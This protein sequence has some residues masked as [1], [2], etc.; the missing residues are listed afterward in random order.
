M[1][2]ITFLW[3][4]SAKAQKETLELPTRDKIEAKYKWNLADIY[5][6]DNQWEKDFKW[7]EN[8]ITEYKKYEGKLS[9][10]AKMLK[11]CLELDEKVG[12][13]LSQAY[14]YASMSKDL[15]LTN[16][17][18]QDMY[19]KISTLASKLSA[20]SA[21][22]KP[23]ILSIPEEKLWEYVN[24]DSY[25]KIYKHYFENILRMKPHTLSKNEEEL[26]ALASPL[27]EVPY[28]AFGYFSNADIQFPIVKDPEG[29]DV[30]ISHGRYYAALESTN[31]DYRERV[32][33]G[34]YKPFIEYKNTLS[35]LFTGNIKGLIFNAK[36]R[37]YN[38]TREASLTPNNIPLSVYDNLITTVNQNLEPMHR[39]AILKKRVL[40]LD[41]LHPYDSYVT[42]FPSVQKKYS[43]DEAK[44]IVIEALKPLGED[45]IKN[46]KTAFDNRWIDVYETKGKR[47][48]AYSSGT[49]IGVHPY[50]L[51]NWNNTL[52]DVFTL[53]HEMGHNMH[54]YYTEKNQPYPYADYSIFIAEVAS[55]LNEALLLDYLIEH[56]KSKE[57]KMALIEK[58]LNSITTTFYRQTNF[59]EM[60]KTANEMMEKGESLTPDKLCKLNGEL[61]QKYWGLAMTVDEEESYSWA[62][63]PH[64]YYNFYVYQYATSYAASQ[65]LIEKIKIEGKPAIEKYLSFLKAG[66]SKYPIDV[67][68]DA[69]VDMRTPE[70]ILAVVH[71]MN[72]LLNELEQLLNEK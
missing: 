52:D 8:A 12:T 29:N 48:G 51:L 19:D 61:Y 47:S 1:G 37:K 9:Q 70:P 25:L 54:S 15:D 62:R 20:A 4:Q 23:E 22:I 17:T 5:A 36:A 31:R 39:W 59:A 56:A 67:L 24:N 72:N 57:E 63:I 18:Y 50:V 68:N 3:S 33:K 41:E 11:E 58:N 69:G 32:Y 65:A 26:L 40:K 46:L 55:T 64:Y 7:L 16:A 42:L 10:S 43:F 45:Y 66:N 34:Y 14:N 71:K 49:I 35:A 21:F 60:E 53:A 2:T 27:E 28:N 38:S 44:N 30:Q 6:D 13:K